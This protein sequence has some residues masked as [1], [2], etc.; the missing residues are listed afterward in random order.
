MR[1]Q[2]RLLLA[3]L[4]T[5]AL[6]GPLAYMWQN[7]R[8]PASYSVMDMGYV[9]YGGGARSAHHQAGVSVA[10]LVEPSDRAADVTVDLV[11]REGTFKLPSGLEVEGF[12]F[13]G[14]SPG[15][16]ITATVGDLVEVHVRN[17]T[18]PEGVSVHWHGIDVPNAEDGVAGVTQDAIRRGEDYT[19]RFVVDHVGTYWYHSH[20]VAH[21]QVQR[22]LFGSF[23]V[24]PERDDQR[25]D[26]AALAHTYAGV[27]TLNGEEEATTVTAPSGQVTRVRVTNTDNS[28]VRVW[29]GTPYR[30]L[31]VDG[32]DVNKPT[33]VEAAYVDVAAGG[34]VDLEVV[35]PARVQVGSTA[36]V[37][38]SDP[39]EVEEP[40]ERLDLLGYG[41]PG[42]PP[43]DVTSPDREF[44]YAIGRRPGFVSGKP[45]LWWS[46]NGHLWPNVPMFL[47]DEGDVV[48][49]TIKN[50]SGDIH[51]MHLHG[52]HAVVLSRDGEP[53]TGSPLWV[54][55]F[56]VANDETVQIAFVADNP[57]IWMD[58]CHNL[59]HAAEGLV[60]HLMYSGVTTPY[61]L[62]SDSGNEPE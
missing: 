1:P 46:I 40:A 58:H 20:Q 32:Y 27:P 10:D 28:S 26:V 9:D 47:V 13:N 56:D 39:G 24:L 14:K 25:L 2:Y 16:T 8:L 33:P 21:S 54:D 37:V 42:P 59:N 52:H 22:G 3:V 35:A 62:G 44:R 19:Y 18:V 23:V 5:A 50:T 57:G 53:A 38:G 7:S 43:L 51:P 55:S 15:P 49:F 45:G 29:S 60:A 48:V 6:L 61:L 31:A 41:S 17:E 34:R 11:A 30:V 36:L 4:A 12:T